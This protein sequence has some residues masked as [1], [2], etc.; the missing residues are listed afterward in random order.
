LTEGR[1][2]V[3][4]THRFADDGPDE[5]S[6]LTIAA[7]IEFASEHVLA[8]AFSSWFVPERSQPSNVQVVQ[9]AGV[10]ATIDGRQFRIGHAEFVSGLSESDAETSFNSNETVVY[11]GDA[12]GVL[13]RF[14]IGD[15][16]RSDAA[17]AIQ[18]LRAAGYRPMI[19]SGDRDGA[20]QRVADQLGIDEWHARLTPA[21][22]LALVRRI[23]ENGESVIMVGDGIND[24]PVLAAA[25]ASIALDAGT[26]LARASADAVSLGRNLGTITHAAKVA[27]AT[28]RIIR[29]NIVWAVAYN[30]TAV[31]LAVSGLLAPW[32][33][34][35]GMSLSSLVV[36]LNALRL[37]RVPEAGNTGMAAATLNPPE[38]EAA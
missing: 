18:T 17:V 4:R 21:D 33:A 28:R 7:S 16:L 37:H 10:E 32:M 19:A 5:D 24:A 15:V 31:P 8:R 27:Q 36:V 3:L 14:D 20:V 38:P 6:L 22:K 23:H 12:N 26:A 34:A 35:I 1:P 13:A 29:Q 2:V 11:L 25:D 9:G 30:L